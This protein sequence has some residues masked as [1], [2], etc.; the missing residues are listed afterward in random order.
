MDQAKQER[1]RNVKTKLFRVLGSDDSVNTCDCCGK[2][3]LKATFAIEMIETGEILRYGSV[4]VTRNTGRKSG[5]LAKMKAAHDQE[6]REAA[7]KE[8]HAT[9]EYAALEIKRKAAFAKGLIGRDFKEACMPERETADRVRA[10]IAARF[11][12]ENFWL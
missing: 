6:R 5:E 10:E 12:I 8:W 2:T 1:A 9:P 3:G 7:R 11:N 4:C